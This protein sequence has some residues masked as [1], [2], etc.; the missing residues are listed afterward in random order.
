MFR[1]KNTASGQSNRTLQDQRLIKTLL[2]A[3]IIVM[4]CCSPLS[5]I[6]FLNVVYQVAIPLRTDCIAAFV[7]YSNCYLNPL[8]YAVRIPEL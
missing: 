5:L 6:D 8:V 7:N 4:V 2:F 3:S 1:Y